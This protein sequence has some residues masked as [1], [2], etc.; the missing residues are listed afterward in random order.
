MH[1]PNLLQKSCNSKPRLWKQSDT[2]L[3]GERHSQR[4]G[5][6]AL[7][8]KWRSQEQPIGNTK[9]NGLLIISES[10]CL[11]ER[12]PLDLFMIGYIIYC[13]LGFH[14]LWKKLKPV[15]YLHFIVSLEVTIKLIILVSRLR[16][17][18]KVTDKISDSAKHL[19]TCLAVNT[20]TIP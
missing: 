4:W 14:S 5:R 7:A 6:A 16:Y 15:L 17:K 10:R 19:S 13:T 9:C 18:S 2:H 3:H 11:L 12:P 20:C 1:K 8:N